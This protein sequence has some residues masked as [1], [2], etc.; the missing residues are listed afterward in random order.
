MMQAETM[1]SIQP[2]PP[3]STLIS[4]EC[5]ARLCSFSRAAEELSLT[6]SAISRQIQQLETALGC[7]LFLRHTHRMS[8][9]P[10]GEA[11]ARQVRQ[12]LLSLSLATADVMGW[13]GSP[14]VTIACSSATGTMLLTEKLPMIRQL[15]PNLQLKVKVTDSFTGLRPAEFDLGIFYLKFVPAGFNA[16]PH[17]DEVCFPAVSPDYFASQQRPEK[18]QDLLSHTLLIQEDPQHEWTGWSDWFHA[19]GV[20]SF[21]PERVWRANNY[22]F[23]VQAAEKS[24]GVLLGWESLIDKQIHSGTLVPALPG[25]LASHWKCYLITSAERHVKP[26]V[27]QIID[28][29]LAH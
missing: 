25:K 20:E 28:C 12:H 29:L 23:L 22:D 24:C 26:E 5:V 15:L 2:L 19:Q 16:V 13:N 3:L 11:F 17:H 7:K 6:Q 14:Q 18:A 27:Q 9:T 21:R 1:R 4:F 10:S 8:L